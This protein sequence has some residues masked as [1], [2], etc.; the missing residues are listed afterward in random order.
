MSTSPLVALVTSNVPAPAPTPDPVP[1]PVPDTNPQWLKL[2]LDL[3]Q[4]VLNRQE[5]L[6]R[7]LGAPQSVVV[8]VGT[9]QVGVSD[10]Q[11][12]GRLGV[13]IPVHVTLDPTATVKPQQ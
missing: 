2:L 4:R 6:E 8:P 7:Q 11:T 5:T 3:L 1:A 9:D 13:V 10:N 12:V